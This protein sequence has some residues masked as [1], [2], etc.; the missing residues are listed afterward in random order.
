M[1]L[2]GTL[3]IMVKYFMLMTFTQALGNLTGVEVMS[4]YVMWIHRL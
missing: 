2:P 4:V 1:H 3:T